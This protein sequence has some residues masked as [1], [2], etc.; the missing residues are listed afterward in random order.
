MA[1]S[2]NA[3]QTAPSGLDLGLHYLIT[4]ICRNILDMYNETCLKPPL[5][6]R[7]NKGLKGGSLV[8]VESIEKCFTGA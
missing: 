3:D 7:Q 8:Q 6:N 1:K 2:V 4:S 5:K